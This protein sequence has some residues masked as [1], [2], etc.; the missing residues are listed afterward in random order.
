MELNP[1]EL[2]GK[3]AYWR[4]VGIWIFTAGLGGIA[5]ALNPQI[6]VIGKAIIFIAL[7][8]SIFF[9]F[10]GG[11]PA[12]YAA[13]ILALLGLLSNVTASCAVFDPQTQYQGLVSIVIAVLCG[14]V[15]HAFLISDD[16]GAYLR[17]LRQERGLPTGD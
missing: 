10:R 7:G 11:D 3:K 14:C 9:L 12:R 2:K 15:W 17:K 8:C 6:S 16:V 1:Q 13:G 4:A 5:Y